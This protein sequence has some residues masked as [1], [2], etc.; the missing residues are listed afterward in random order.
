MGYKLGRRRHQD[1][2]PSEDDLSVA[3]RYDLKT[4]RRTSP[5]CSGVVS[6]AGRHG[7]DDHLVAVVEDQ[8]HG[9]QQAGPGVE[10][11]TQLPLGRA[12]VEGLN[13]QRPRGRLDRIPHNNGSGTVDESRRL[14]FAG[15]MSDSTW[16]RMAIATVLGVASGLALGLAAH[17]PIAAMGGWVIAGA[18]FVGW[19][20]LRLAPLDGTATRGEATRQDPGRGADDI[21]L[22]AASLGAVLGVGVLI[23]VSSGQKGNALVAAAGILGVAASWFVV[24]TMFAIRYARLYYA[25]PSRPIDFNSDSDPT[26]SDFGYL[27]FTIGMTYQVADTNLKSRVIRHTVLRHAMIA[28]LLGAVILACTINLVS[29]LASGGG[30]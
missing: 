9:L 3:R 27:A 22:L 13:P 18:T 12:V 16:F 21:V 1:D 14:V 4:V 8:D 11:Q 20:W 25:D 17:T 5:S 29:Q 15:L 7:V 26:F 10:T 24:H 2:T 30:G 6:S 23:A 28:F 19:T